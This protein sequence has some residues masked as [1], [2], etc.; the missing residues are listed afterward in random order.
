M[1]VVLNDEQILAVQQVCP[2]CLLA[3]HQGL[4]RWQRGNL[5]CAKRLAGEQYPLSLY[6]C[7]MGFRLAN[8]E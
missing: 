6:E 4:P 1:L 7:Q 8:V 2:N 3:N 5:R